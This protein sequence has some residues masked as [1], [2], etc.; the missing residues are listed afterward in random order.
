MRQPDRLQSGVRLCF[1][2]LVPKPACAIGQGGP[3]AQLDRL[4]E[5]RQA[6]PLHYRVE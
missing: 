2:D 6:S 3:A 1:P 4:V 5:G